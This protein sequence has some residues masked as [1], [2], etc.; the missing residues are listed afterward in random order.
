MTENDKLKNYNVIVGIHKVTNFE[1]WENSDIPDK[2]NGIGCNKESWTPGPRMVQ[3]NS[4][5]ENMSKENRELMQEKWRTKMH[6][7]WEEIRG[8]QAKWNA[9][10]DK[11]RQFRQREYRSLSGNGPG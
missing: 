5:G 2:T 6:N 4:K 8:L 1:F 7:E 11:R 3:G 10:A 9:E